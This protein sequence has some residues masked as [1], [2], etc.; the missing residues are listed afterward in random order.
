M[1]ASKAQSRQGSF[2]LN[3]FAGKKLLEKRIWQIY[4][5]ES[6]LICKKKK[7]AD[8]YNICMSVCECV[9]VV[10][11]SDIIPFW[12]SKK[13]DLWKDSVPAVLKSTLSFHVHVLG[14]YLSECVCMCVWDPSST[15]GSVSV[16]IQLSEGGLEGLQGGM[17]GKSGSTFSFAHTPGCFKDREV[18]MCAAAMFM[19]SVNGCYL[20]K[21]HV[22]LSTLGWYNLR[23]HMQKWKMM[24]QLKGNFK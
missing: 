7:T 2:L 18:G 6:L 21:R 5:A 16:Q 9:W 11:L 3:F 15:L 8:A 22:L 10:I 1:C 19:C 14:W 13:E 20:I 17:M 4:E 12:L 24:G 23:V